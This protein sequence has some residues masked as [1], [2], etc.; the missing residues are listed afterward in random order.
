MEQYISANE[1]RFFEKTDS[2]TIQNAVDEA[3][4]GDIRIV[5]IP[6]KCARTGKCE[7]MIDEPILLPSNITIILDDC[8]LTLVK[9]VYSNIFRNKNMYTDISNKPEGRQHGIR[10]IGVGDAIL[11]G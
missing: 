9:D 7:W 3:A 8:H 5:R 4:K 2:R 10:I 11:D 6:H 1:K